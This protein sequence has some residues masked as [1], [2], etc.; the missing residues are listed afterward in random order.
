MYACIHET[1]SGFFAGVSA[2][3]HRSLLPCASPPIPALHAL[4]LVG[5]L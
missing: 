1:D 4:T 5:T 3:G 2:S